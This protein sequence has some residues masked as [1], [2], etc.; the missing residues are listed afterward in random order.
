MKK[1][2]PFSTF[3]SISMSKARLFF[4]Y[5]DLKI[6]NNLTSNWKKNGQQS[7]HLEDR[8]SVETWSGNSIK[9]LKAVIDCKLTLNVLGQHLNLF[10]T[11][12]F[13]RKQ[14]NLAFE[15]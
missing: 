1:S 6:R 10:E 15:V 5:I 11:R 2:I 12:N 8:P 13:H 9:A 14:T 7:A 4:L 3:V